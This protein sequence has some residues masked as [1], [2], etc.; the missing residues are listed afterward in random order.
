M[1]HSEAQRRFAESVRKPDGQINLA[2][3][4][5]LFACCEHPDLDVPAYL[6]K[7][8]GLAEEA[9]F[10]VDARP[11]PI[12]RIRALAAFFG[13]AGFRGSRENYY[14]PRNSYLNEV[15]DRR[16]GLPISLSVVFLDLAGRLEIPVHGVGLPAHFIV[17]WQDGPQELFIDPFHGAD[18]LTEAECAGRVSAV[19]GRPVELSPSHFARVGPRQV[20]RRMF[21]NLR[22]VY[23]SEKD[24][25][26]AV[27]TVECLLILDP[28]SADDLRDL[29][30]LYHYSDRPRESAVCFERYLELAPEAPD[31]AVVERNLELLRKRMGG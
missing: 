9:R 21:N 7:L 31:A 24:L 8:A 29:G 10:A 6:G 25:P 27:R 11:E 23:L 5:L 17:K 1:A 14:D 30:N 19:M 28:D 12:E 26:R 20:L 15:I 4:A 3:S 16:T 2:E 18:I 13:G 22:S